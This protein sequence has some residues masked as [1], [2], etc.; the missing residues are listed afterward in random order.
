MIQQQAGRFPPPGRA[1]YPPRTYSPPPARSHAPVG[2]AHRFGP[3]A[4]EVRIRPRAVWIALSWLLFA[5]LVVAGVAT[6][7]VDLMGQEVP[8]GPE[9]V[10]AG[11]EVVEVALDPADQPVLYAV[12]PGPGSVRCRPVGP[13]ADGLRL[14]PTTTEWSVTAQ[15]R[16]WHAA[17]H[18]LPAARGTYRIECEGAAT[19]FGIGGKA[20]AAPSGG[21]VL[22]LLLLP[23][24]GFV[25]A[26]TTTI[27]VLARR[28]GAQDRLFA[29][30][31]SAP[32]PPSW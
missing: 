23:L 29:P 13:A 17:F 32:P 26:V 11:G 15:G 1:P 24:I 6:V 14:D 27:V 16:E 25:T 20:P 8:A 30:W 4:P 10:F 12:M 21:A 22:A 7:V 5:L 18:V 3:P 31:T 28:R 2:P 9:R 19:A